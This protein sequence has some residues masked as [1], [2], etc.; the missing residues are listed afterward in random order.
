[1]SLMGMGTRSSSTLKFWDLYGRVP[2]DDWLFKTSRLAHPDILRQTFTE[3]LQSELPVMLYAY[4]NRKLICELVSYVKTICIFGASAVLLGVLY[5][6]SNARNTK[7]LKGKVSFSAISKKGGR[8]GKKINEME[9]GWVD[10][11][12]E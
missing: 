11:E 3:S 4:R 9:D 5:K 2:H 12:E 6:Q 8:K 7:R 10:M 1:M